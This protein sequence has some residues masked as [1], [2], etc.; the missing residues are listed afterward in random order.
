MGRD[1]LS[2]GSHWQI[3]VGEDVRVWV[4]KWLPS[5]PLGHP[6]RF[7]RLLSPPICRLVL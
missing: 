6:E 2:S 4:D 3:M 1:L 7:E 5:L